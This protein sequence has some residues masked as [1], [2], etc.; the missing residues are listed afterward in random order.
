[1]GCESKILVCCR[2]QQLVIAIWLVVFSS[3]PLICIWI[4]DSFE[5]ADVS[6]LGSGIDFCTTFPVSLGAVLQSRS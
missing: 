5:K 1:M 2:C 6:G 4:L 3:F